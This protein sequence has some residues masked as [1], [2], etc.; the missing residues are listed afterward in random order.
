MVTCRVQE[1][2]E[3]K[4]LDFFPCKPV[5][6]VEYEGFASTI[7]PGIK[8]KCVCCPPDP[9]AGAHCIWEFYIDE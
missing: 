2:R 7:D 3:R 4:K 6:L 5:G 1:A 9:V 8:T